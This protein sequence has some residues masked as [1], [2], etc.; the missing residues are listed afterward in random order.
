MSRDILK[1]LDSEVDSF[2]ERASGEEFYEY[3]EKIAERAIEEDRNSFVDAM[4]QW[5]LLRA[6][7]KTM[8]AVEMVG[9]YRVFEL[10][11]ELEKL[12]SDVITGKVF[13]LFY[14][15]PIKRSLDKLKIDLG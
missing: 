13:K 7:P 15:R 3:F 4:M 11:E 5:L 1:W 10:K 8:I 14:E 6:E 9:K 2:P 12:L